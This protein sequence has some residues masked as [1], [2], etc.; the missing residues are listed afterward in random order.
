[1]ALN[2]SH[3]FPLQEKENQSLIAQITSLQEENFKK[4]RAVEELEK[5]VEEYTSITE[6]LKAD[7]SKLETQVQMF[8]P[9]MSGPSLSVAYRLNQSTSGSLQTELALAQSPLEG[10]TGAKM[11]DETLDKEVLLLLQGPNP[12]HMALEFRGLLRKMKT[13]FRSEACSVLSTVRRHLD[14]QQT[15]PEGST[16]PGLQAVQ[17]EL[18]ARRADWVLGLD[19]LA[20][21]TDSLEKE[22]IKMASNMRRSHTEILHLSVRVQKQENQ[23]RQLGEELEQ[24]RTPQDSREASCQAG[25]E[26]EWDAEFDLLKKELAEGQEVVATVAETP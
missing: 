12:E 22:L 19:Q 25:E 17:G 16:E 10:G 4:S 1:M 26:L 13:E 21:Y 6:R 20:Q 15:P 23:K 2:V 18:E 24:L 5:V 8:Y 3:A 9:V 14:H 7:K 11:L